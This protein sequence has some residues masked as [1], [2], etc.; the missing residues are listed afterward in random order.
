MKRRNKLL[1]TTAITVLLVGSFYYYF[2]QK[3][4][5]HFH[6]VREGVLY[7]SGQPRGLGLEW[8]RL[9]GIRTLINLRSPDSDGTPEEKLYAAENGLQFYNFSIGSSHAEI[10][11]TVKRFLAIVDDKSHWPIL[12]HCSRGKE[13]SG[14][15]SA[16]YRIEHDRWTNEQAL[17]ETYRLGLDRGHMP[18]PENYIKSY[19]PSWAPHQDITPA[20]SQALPA[21]PWQD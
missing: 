3:S 15:L 11:A 6:T 16:I 14:V 17:E 10:D 1:I 21:V 18:I 7:R 8:I 20:P 5:P 12:V 13:R 9:H 4:L 2:V 19:R